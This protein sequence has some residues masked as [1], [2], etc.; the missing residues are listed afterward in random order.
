MKGGWRPKRPLQATG[1]PHESI[2]RRRT[3]PAKANAVSSA[4]FADRIDDVLSDPVADVG[5]TFIV[6]IRWIETSAHVK[7]CSLDEFTTNAQLMAAASV[8]I[9]TTNSSE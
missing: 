6:D 5:R 8:Y 7:K 2:P 4:S 1:L 9:N 3:G